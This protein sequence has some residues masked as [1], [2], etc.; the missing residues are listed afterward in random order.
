MAHPS[1]HTIVLALTALCLAGCTSGHPSR[2]EATSARATRECVAGDFKISSGASG[3][4]QGDASYSI[5]L[6]NVSGISCA[7]IGA[8]PMTV[9]LLSGAEEQVTLGSAAV[10]SLDVG[11][12]QVLQVMIGSPGSCTNISPPKPASTLVM[13]LPG[14][15]PIVSAIRLDV[16]CGAPIVLIFGS[17]NPP[18]SPS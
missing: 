18:A 16:Q 13:R 2:T 11:A 1:R 12:D 3:A 8:P 5:V 10:E 15:T 14:E 9:S 7:L 4:Y 6:R 17:F